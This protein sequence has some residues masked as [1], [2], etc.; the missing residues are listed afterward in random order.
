MSMLQGFGFTDSYSETGLG[1]IFLWRETCQSFE[2]STAE[3]LSKK[4][5]ANAIGYTKIHTGRGSVHFDCK[6]KLSYKI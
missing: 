6:L 5:H 1:R 4:I 3:F 2:T